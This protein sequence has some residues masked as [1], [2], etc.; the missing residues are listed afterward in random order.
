ME[1][2]VKTLGDFVEILKRRKISL[3]VPAAIVFIAAVVVAFAWPPVYRSTSTILIEEQE[4]PKDFVMATVTGFAEQ[5]LQTIN[6]RIMSTTRLLDI[7]SR[8]NL[9]ADMKDRLTVEEIVANMRK[10]IQFAT[11]SADVAERR[12]IAFTLS[13]A[14]K[15]PDVVQQVANILTSLYLEEN[16]KVREQQARGTSRFLE[17]EAKTVQENLEKIEAKISVFKQKN[18]NAL[19]ELMQVNMQAL[20]RTEREID[21]LKD[22]LRTLKEKESYLQAQLASIPTTESPNQERTLLKELKAKLVQL[23]SRVSDKYPDVIKTKAEIAELEKRLNSAPAPAN[24]QAGAGK[25]KVAAADHSDNP[26]YVTL[27]SQLAGTQADLDSVQRQIKDATRKWENYRQRLAVTPRVDE[28]F[29]ALLGERNNTQLKYDDLMKKVLEARVAQ[30]LEREQMG[31]RFTLIDPPRLP[32]KPASPNRPAIL[33]IGFVLAF[34]VGIGSA[35]LREHLDTSVRSASQVTAVTSVPVLGAIP[36]IVT[37][38]DQV[39]WRTRRK[40]VMVGAVLAVVICV[41]AFHFFI[42]DLD[43]FWARMVRKLGL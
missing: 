19:P 11:I 33:L 22:Q 25:R 6:Q 10:D 13:Y 29:K 37:W 36:E 39:R 30:G 12:T 34:G 27:A 18:L 35:S 28:E 4:I 16:L 3:I 24:D 8:F 5:R 23:Q 32:E 14:G 41:V 2:D 20:D 21:H 40:N 9:Y 38:K 1:Q 43:V 17:E 31:E 15:R 7:I 26:A 42:M